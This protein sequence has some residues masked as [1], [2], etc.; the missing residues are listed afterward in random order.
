MEQNSFSE[1]T[2][3]ILSFVATQK[4]SAHCFFR[5]LKVGF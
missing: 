3:L 2:D 1:P 5:Y 4:N